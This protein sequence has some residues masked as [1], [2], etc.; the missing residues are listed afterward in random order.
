MIIIKRLNLAGKSLLEYKREFNKEY[1]EI[2][3][4]AISSTVQELIG[5]LGLNLCIFDSFK[6]LSISA[7][8]FERELLSIKDLAMTEKEIKQELEAYLKILDKNLIG[9]GVYG[10]EKEINI[11]K[12]LLKIVKKIQL[13]K[14]FF[15]EYFL[16]DNQELTEIMKPKG[17][18]DRF[19]TQRIGK[20]FNDIE[21]DL[22][23][24]FAIV[25]IERTDVEFIDES[26]VASLKISF[27]G[28]AVMD[29]LDEL[30]AEVKR[31]ISYSS[32]YIQDRML[33]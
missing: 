27:N 16:L 6:D 29:K 4:K 28:L 9:N 23:S 25:N 8:S 32:K 20:L 7:D 33:I 19:S 3:Q 12:E 15:Q 13:D 14:T 18:A 21:G 11:G 2:V 5:V 31:F 1:P 22:S 10:Y 30:T 24:E 26:Y 17:F